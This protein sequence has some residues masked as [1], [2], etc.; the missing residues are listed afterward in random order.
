M[1]EE[2]TK[3][4]LDDYIHQQK[5]REKYIKEKSVTN[6]V[7]EFLG[8]ICESA[9]TPAISTGF[10]EL[11]CVLE[12]GLYEGLYIV[13]AVSS[14]GKTTFVLQIADQIAQHE[15]DVLIFSLEMSQYERAMCS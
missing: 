9:N 3:Q 6:M 14:L 12:G 5:R 1:N 13:G 11:D 2:N 10:T 15:Q 4:Y 7:S 8:G